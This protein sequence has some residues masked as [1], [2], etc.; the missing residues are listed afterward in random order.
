MRRT[1]GYFCFLWY[2]VSLERRRHTTRAATYIAKYLTK[3]I[4][5]P[6]GRKRY[7]ASRNLR[8]PTEERLQMTAEEY[9]EIFNGAR[10]QKVINSP[11]GMFLLCET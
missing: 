7:W 6:K 9:G 5:V 3:D 4:Q 2:V 1:T 11:W 10:Y 8:R